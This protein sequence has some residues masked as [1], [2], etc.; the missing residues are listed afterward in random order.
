MTARSLRT[1]EFERILLIKPSA[2][3]D[4]LHTVP[5]LVKLRQRYP[6]A[7][8]DWLITP[9][10][11]DIVRSHPAL[12]NVVLFVRKDLEQIGRSWSV[13]SRFLQ[14]LHRLWSTHYDLVIDA[15][16]QFRSA[17]LTLATGAPVR[18]GFSRPRRRIAAV[19]NR[20]VETYR[21]GWTGAREGSWLAYTHHIPI[22]TLEAHAVD[23]YLWIGPMLAL[24]DSP[25]DFRLYTPLETDQK[26]SILL[27]DCGLDGRPM[28]VLFPGTI[29]STKH[30]HVEG[31]AEVGK[32][33]HRRGFDVALCGG[34]SDRERSRQVAAA[35]PEAIDLT[36]RTTVDEAIA[37]VRRAALCLTNDSGPMHLAV[38]LDR[39]V[40]SVF[41]PTDE[42]R[43]GPYGRPNAVVRAEMPC[44]PCYL[45][46]IERCPNGHACMK[47]VTSRMVIERVESILAERLAA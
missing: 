47:Q 13:T 36:G 6:E 16:G 19:P 33:L 11:S 18:I 17:V 28:A 31:F 14:L 26:L 35:C 32:H 5:L 42:G 24:D 9:E 8:I 22:P 40:V 10:N 46:S 2:F 25:P 29:W 41:G 3:G 7:R 30:W 21:R 37:L 4:V 39:P 15:H 23:R 1:R 44:A 34:P 27:T 43:I 45:R 20:P 12:S 38:S